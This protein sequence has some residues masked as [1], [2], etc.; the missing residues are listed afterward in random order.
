VIQRLITGY[1]ALTD[2]GEAVRPWG[3]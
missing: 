1:R 3:H 2:E